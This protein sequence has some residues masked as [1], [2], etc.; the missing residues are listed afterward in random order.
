[1]MNSN[2]LRLV[3]LDERAACRPCRG[4]CSTKNW[5]V[6]RGV[7]VDLAGGG[8]ADVLLERHHRLH[9]RLTVLA[10]GDGA[11]PEAELCEAE[12]DPA[13]S[14]TRCEL[15]TA[16]NG[17]GNGR[18]SRRSAAASWSVPQ[19]W[20]ERQWWWALPL[21][22]A[23]AVVVVAIGGR[24]RARRRIGARG[25]RAGDEPGEHG[26]RERQCNRAAERADDVGGGGAIMPAIR[27]HASEPRLHAQWP[28]SS[29]EVGQLTPDREGVLDTTRR[30]CSC[31]A[32]G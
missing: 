12:L 10:V 20:W 23:R 3:D 26:G 17:S 29:G 2:C 9:G 31:G 15:P 4:A 1:M 16:A 14:R 24:G 19:W 7:C 27:T 6:R 28:S 5:Q 11:G 25:L 13:R 21:W 8:Q 30:S 18:R 22:S 32:D